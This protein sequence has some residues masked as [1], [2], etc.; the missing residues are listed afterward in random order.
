MNS[1]TPFQKNITH[2]QIL[3]KL[4]EYCVC[5]SSVANSDSTY[6]QSYV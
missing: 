4:Q 6:M 5:L 1:N 2:R 3:Y